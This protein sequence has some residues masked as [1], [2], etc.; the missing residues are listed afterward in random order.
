LHRIIK[1]LGDLQKAGLGERN[2]AICRELT[3]R[4]EEV[5]RMTVSQAL[6][7]FNE[8]A[9]RGEFVLVMEGRVDGDVLEEIDLSEEEKT[10]RV[11][12]LQ[13]KG[14]PTKEMAGILSKEWGVTKKEAYS[15]IIKMIN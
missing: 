15:F 1:T 7:H 12:Q 6:L 2:V 10:E 8:Q 9:P 4:Y 3:K 11:A 5:L 13:E 14:L